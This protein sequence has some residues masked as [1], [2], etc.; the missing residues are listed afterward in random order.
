[1]QRHNWRGGRVAACWL[2][3]CRVANAFLP[4]PSSRHC[5]HEE[6]KPGDGNRNSH[7]LNSPLTKL[8]SSHDPDGDSDRMEETGRN[9]EAQTVRQ[10]IRARL[11]LCA[12]RVTVEERKDPDD[13]H[14]HPDWR[15][16]FQRY[17]D[18][19][20]DRRAGNANFHA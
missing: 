8:P 20:Y 7:A 19:K 4:L 17:R 6:D 3:A 15:L 9:D 2:C 10:C 18:P 1:M 13:C 14:A 5:A 12:M 16:R 11:E